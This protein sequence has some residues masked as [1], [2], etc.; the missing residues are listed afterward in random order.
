M[1]YK[2]WDHIFIGAKSTYVSEIIFST[3]E[4][5]EKYLERF[6]KEYWKENIFH[7]N[8]W[9]NFVEKLNKNARKKY[10][11]G[12][13]EIDKARYWEMLEVLPPEKY[14]RAEG[15]EI[16]RMS[17]YMEGNITNHF[18]RKWNKYYEG[19]FDTTDYW[20]ILNLIKENENNK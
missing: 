8:N 19:Y 20:S 2:D 7:N 3:K 13:S 14:T 9:E 5:L 18:M 17:E 10:C 15:V 16:F 4:V 6:E 1:N 11:K 12:W